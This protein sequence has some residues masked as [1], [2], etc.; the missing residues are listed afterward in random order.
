[1]MFYL[2]A[3]KQY[4]HC[5]CAIC[6]LALEFLLLP[7]CQGKVSTWLV[8]GAQISADTVAVSNNN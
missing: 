4:W 1:M 7:I 6:L 2:D 3:S 8:L 5:H